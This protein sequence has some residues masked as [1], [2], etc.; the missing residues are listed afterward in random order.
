MIS[1]FV[2]ILHNEFEIELPS[3]CS[4]MKPRHSNATSSRV[5]S[6]IVTSSSRSDTNICFA[7]ALVALTTNPRKARSTGCRISSNI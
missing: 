1:H 7:C 3:A 2:M 4:K 6:S 5:R